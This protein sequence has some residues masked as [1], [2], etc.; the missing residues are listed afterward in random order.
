ME[1]S[2]LKRQL[3]TLITMLMCRL[4]PVTWEGQEKLLL[5]VALEDDRD[6]YGGLYSSDDEEEDDDG[7][8]L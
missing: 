5:P 8:V 4:N 7:S 1:Q 3:S 6:V 2:S